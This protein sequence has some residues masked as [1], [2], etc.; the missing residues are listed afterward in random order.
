MEKMMRMVGEEYGVVV[1][2]ASQTVSVTYESNLCVGEFGDTKHI[3]V[4]V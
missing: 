1:V 2:M 3:T 4:Y